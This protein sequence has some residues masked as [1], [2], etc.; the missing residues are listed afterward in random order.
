MEPPQ[1]KLAHLFG[2]LK[3]VTPEGVVLR[4]AVVVDP[5]DSAY[6]FR[7][8]PSLGTPYF[9]WEPTPH[10]C[11][12]R[13]ILQQLSWRLKSCVM[14]STPHMLGYVQCQLQKCV[15]PVVRELADTVVGM[16]V[17]EAPEE[18]PNGKR[19]HSCSSSCSSSSSSSS[20]STS[21]ST[22]TSHCSSPA[23]GQSRQVRFAQCATCRGM[24]RGKC[25]YPLFL[26][27][28]IAP[29]CIMCMLP[30][31]LAKTDKLDQLSHLSVQFL[32][33]HR[34]LVV[35]SCDPHPSAGDFLSGR[36]KSS[37]P[38]REWYHNFVRSG[39]PRREE[40]LNLATEI[41]KWNLKQFQLLV[42]EGHATPH[43]SP[44]KKDFSVNYPSTLWQETM[45]SDPREEE[46]LNGPPPPPLPPP[47]DLRR[48]RPRQNGTQCRQKR[49]T[50]GCPYQLSARELS[51]QRRAA[52]DPDL[53]R[54][55]IQSTQSGNLVEGWMRS[56]P[57]GP[58]PDI[59]RP[60]LPF[61]S[62]PPPP[63]PS[64]STPAPPLL[65]PLP[66]PLHSFHYSC[67]FPGFERQDLGE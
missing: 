2:E 40:M 28:T 61:S 1:H 36:P 4:V 7:R 43:C 57:A 55:E 5:D 53:L 26:N 24:K 47:V 54:E 64:P 62:P 23:T 6:D 46:Q 3:L 29:C 9:P 18:T 33:N 13:N 41:N 35:N 15:D 22:S 17:V 60:P 37:L 34:E 14:I 58:N 30:R 51:L 25:A 65:Q 12:R 11:A 48:Q 32:S 27:G 63:P 67:Y 59:L 52:L 16:V 10:D 31:S 39:D 38:L 56:L 21:I 42:G 44:S 20:S 49:T 8:H 19:K 66:S 50:R 45:D